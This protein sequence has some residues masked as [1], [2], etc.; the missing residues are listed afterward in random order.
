MNRPDSGAFFLA[1]TKK[2]GRV[3]VF[4]RQAVKVS[5][6]VRVFGGRAAK[7]T[8]RYVGLHGVIFCGLMNHSGRPRQDNATEV[9]YGGF[10]LRNDHFVDVNKMIGVGL[11]LSRGRG[12]IRF[13]RFLQKRKLQLSRAREMRQLFGKSEFAIC[14][15]CILLFSS[16]SPL[17]NHSGRVTITPYKSFTA[18][19]FLA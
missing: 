7:E 16:S 10:F 19:F 4:D 5:L 1:G 2:R 11:Q 15:N 12:T 6:F 9:I 8:T 18:L 13:W 3:R 14:K 17:M